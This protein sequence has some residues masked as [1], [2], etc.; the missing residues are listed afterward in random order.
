MFFWQGGSYVQVL[1]TGSSPGDAEVAVEIARRI[2]G[3]IQDTGEEMWALDLL[4]ESGR[5]PDSFAFLARDAFGLGFL[6]DVFTARYDVEGR[7]FSL[8]IH[9]A[10]DESSAATLL[11]EYER[12]FEKYGKVTWKSPDA[13]RRIITGKVAGL[14]DVVF[15]KGRYLGGVS[16]ADDAELARRAAINFYEVLT[17]P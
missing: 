4:P 12:F 9:R 10:G 11:D 14:T 13:S 16:G 3:E 6:T 7:Q 2:N 17:S 15:A 8:F 1:P 5:V